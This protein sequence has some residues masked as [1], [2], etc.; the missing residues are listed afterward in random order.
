MLKIIFK[1]YKIDNKIFAIDFDSV[2][3]NT[4]IIPHLINLCNIYFGGKFFHQRSTYHIL[5]LYV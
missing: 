2:Y 1:E 4:T 3:N 5:N